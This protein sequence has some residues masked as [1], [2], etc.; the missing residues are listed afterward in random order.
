MHDTVDITIAPN[1][2]Y[3]KVIRG[4]AEFDDP[5]ETE[6]EFKEQSD[7]HEASE[8]YLKTIHNT[9]DAEEYVDNPDDLPTLSWDMISPASDP[10]LLSKLATYFDGMDPDE[11]AEKLRAKCRLLPVGVYTDAQVAAKA[12]LRQE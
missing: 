9:P 12:E 1:D 5:P 8:A 10:D 6:A 7:H 11:P 3:A 2:K 4:E